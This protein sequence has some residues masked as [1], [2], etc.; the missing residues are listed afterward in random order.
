M[1]RGPTY[2]VPR[3]RRREGKTNYYKRYVY[4]TSRAVRLVV[5]KSNRYITAQIIGP[6]PIGDITLAAVH[7][8]ELVK[9]L[10]WLGGAKN[11]P[12]A[13][14][15]GLLLGI[16]ARLMGVEEAALDIGLHASVKGSRL[17]ALAR[18]AIDA[19][20][21]IS[22]DDEMLP[23]WER[24]RGGDIARYAEELSSKDPERFKRQFSEILGRGLD[25]RKLPE[26]FD[27]V[28]SR[29]IELGRKLGVEVRVNER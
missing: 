24:I 14:L 4:I 25:P 22:V 5:R 16:K 19:G 10:G 18:G 11:T 7:T 20:L 12:A 6:T 13:Y 21:K 26:H 9:K 29:I 3:R 15:A 2:R 17:Y 28:F 27:Q 8:S 1:A 23:S